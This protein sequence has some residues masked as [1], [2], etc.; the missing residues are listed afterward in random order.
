MPGFSENIGWRAGF[1]CPALYM[2]N[3]GSYNM[4][5]SPKM[6][7]FKPA[8]ATGDSIF[9]FFFFFLKKKN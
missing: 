8:H 2:A 9:F 7:L 4:C 5:V 1:G 3:D 6:K